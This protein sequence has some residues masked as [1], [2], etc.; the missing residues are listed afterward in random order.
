M[1]ETF[2]NSLHENIMEI[3]EK[4]I[5]HFWMS[6][7]YVEKNSSLEVSVNCKPTI[8]HTITWELGS[9]PFT[10]CYGNL[11]IISEG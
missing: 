8:D 11:I 5:F 9:M 6:R 7:Y 10:K 3:Q 2:L 1:A 4:N